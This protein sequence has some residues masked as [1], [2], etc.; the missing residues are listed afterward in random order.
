MVTDKK[1]KTPPGEQAAFGIVEFW[2]GWQP[3]LL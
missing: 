2:A 3:Y 1:Q